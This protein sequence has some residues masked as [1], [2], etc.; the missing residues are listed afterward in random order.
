RAFRVAAQ[1]PLNN[2]ALRALDEHLNRI[3]AAKAAM[4]TRAGLVR[5]FFERGVQQQ[6]AATPQS[7][8]V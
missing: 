7:L 6:F 1:R 5:C 2:N 4:V 8:A 3:A